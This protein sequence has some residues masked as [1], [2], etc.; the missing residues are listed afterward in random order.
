M[1]YLQRK[2]WAKR[3]K[4]DL[5]WR[6]FEANKHGNTFSKRL[7]ISS[8]GIVTAAKTRLPNLLFS[9]SGVL[10]PPFMTSWSCWMT[11]LTVKSKGTW[12]I[13]I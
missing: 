11:W 2:N 9:D 7:L 13:K 10:I 3:E 1:K 6:E 4:I 5:D 8:S 12:K